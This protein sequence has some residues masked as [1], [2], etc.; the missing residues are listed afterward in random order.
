MSAIQLL[1]QLGADAQKRSEAKTIFSEKIDNELP[2][3]RK[4]WCLMVPEKDDEEETDTP[5]PSDS[6]KVIMH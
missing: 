4:Q 5:A 2:E 3:N 6:D 1:A